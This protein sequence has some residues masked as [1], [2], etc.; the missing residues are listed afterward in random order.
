MVKMRNVKN[1]MN[2]L[3]MFWLSKI[4]FVNFFY[5]YTLNS[6]KKHI[7]ILANCGFDNHSFT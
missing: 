4:Q 6:F 1:I 7:I 2:Y 3:G 5:F